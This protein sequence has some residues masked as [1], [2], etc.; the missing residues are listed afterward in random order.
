MFQQ[1][2]KQVWQELI[3]NGFKML[4]RTNDCGFMWDCQEG[5]KNLLF[6]VPGDPAITLQR[7]CMILQASDPYNHD[8]NY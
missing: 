1:W 6:F 2:D 3:K 4:S 8:A 7:C 5:C